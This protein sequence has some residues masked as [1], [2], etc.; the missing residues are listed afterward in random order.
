MKTPI[1]LITAGATQ[2]PLDPVRYL[3]NRSSGKFG[4]ALAQAFVDLGWQVI[5]ISGPT[6][7]KTPEGVNFYRI[8]TA[9][10]MFKAVK[11]HAKQATLI[12]KAG[13]VADYTPVKISSAKIKKVSTTLTLKLKRTPDI[14]QWLGDHKKKDQILIGFCAETHHAKK[15]ALAKMHKKNLDGIIVNTVSKKNP[16]FDVDENEILFLSRTGGTVFKAK[17]SKVKLSQKI[18]RVFE[19]IQST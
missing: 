19:T 14:L 4:Y 18:A 3:S 8:Q 5:L 10:D 1:V 12:L 17:D 15:N 13:A 16:A 6:S 7:L 9:Q 2:E 11:K